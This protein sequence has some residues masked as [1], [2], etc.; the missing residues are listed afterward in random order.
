MIG[1]K[2]LGILLDIRKA[3]DTSNHELLLLKLEQ[4][5]I[6]GVTLNRFKSYLLDRKQYVSIASGNSSI[7][8]NQC[9]VLQGSVLGHILFVIFANDQ[10]SEPFKGLSDSIC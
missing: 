2:V 7:L 10:Y 9:G 3:L 1:N 6:R 8:K 5:G 4:S